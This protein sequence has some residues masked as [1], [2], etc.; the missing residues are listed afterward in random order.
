M[1]CQ[2]RKISSNIRLYN[3]FFEDV[4]PNGSDPTTNPK[5]FW[6]GN[7]KEWD[8]VLKGIN[9]VKPDF[10]TGDVRSEDSSQR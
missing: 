3:I 10:I 7:T 9:V 6:V 8:R 2:E 1:K 4:H 5:Y